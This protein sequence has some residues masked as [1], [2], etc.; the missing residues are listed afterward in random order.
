[1]DPYFFFSN[2]IERCNYY[3]K[4]IKLAILYVQKKKKLAILAFP[5]NVCCDELICTFSDPLE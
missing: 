3:S 5:K 1:M 2:S 4:S